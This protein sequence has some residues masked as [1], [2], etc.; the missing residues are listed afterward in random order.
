MQVDSWLVQCWSDFARD[1]QYQASLHLV[2]FP[3]FAGIMPIELDLQSYYH[4]RNLWITK[5]SGNY[6]RPTLAID[7]VVT[8][9]PTSE[10][11]GL[12]G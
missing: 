5:Y 10:I 12:V 3:G 8:V 4:H 9:G 11:V 2:N 6:P 7:E 1:G